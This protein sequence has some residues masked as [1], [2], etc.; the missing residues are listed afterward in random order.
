MYERYDL[1]LRCEIT[2]IVPVVVA[3]T[4]PYLSITSLSWIMAWS[5]WLRARSTPTLP[6]PE[7][8]IDGSVSMIQRYRQ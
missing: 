3:Y 4:K 8:D 5:V 2:Q 6:E 7:D 1:V